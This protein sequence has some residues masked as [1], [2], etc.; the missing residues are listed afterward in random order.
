V[1]SWPP[2]APQPMLPCAYVPN[3]GSPTQQPGGSPAAAGGL[4]RILAPGTMISG[5]F[6]IERRLARG[7]QASVYLASQMPLNRPV[8]LKVL[9]PPTGEATDEEIAVFERRFLLEARTLAALDHPNIVTIF[10]YGETGDGRFYLAMEYI[11]GQR[12]LDLLTGGRLEQGRAVGLTLQICRALRYSHHQGVVHRD[13][14]NSNV[15]VRIDDQ[16]QEQVKV[17]DF[18]LVKLAR[19]DSNITQTGMILGSPHFMAP[20]QATGEGVDHRVDIYATGVLLYCALVGEYPFDGPHATAIITA[21]MTRTAQAFS[22]AAPDAAIPS[23]LEAIVFKCLEKQPGQRYPSMEALIA[24]LRV[25]EVNSPIGVMSGEF[26]T[27][28]AHPAHPAVRTWDWSKLNTGM[29]IGG[30]LAILVALLGLAALTVITLTPVQQTVAPR[31]PIAPR[32][33][34]VPVEVAPAQPAPPDQ[35]AATPAE[36]KPAAK[37]V[38]PRKP[39]APKRATPRTE[40]PVKKPRVKTRETRRPRTD[41]RDPWAE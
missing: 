27:L 12:F 28:T 20:E 21:H 16:G 31:A 2:P 25:F 7:G 34:A 24:D 32:A 38:A 4:G 22:A 11:A 9:A 19:V 6:R 3:P 40:K 23:G 14:K 26:H 29:L 30:V 5:K 39:G 18:G 10:D 1:R 41:S 15:L 37:V 36:R 33:V 35:E 13:V 17:V 8:A